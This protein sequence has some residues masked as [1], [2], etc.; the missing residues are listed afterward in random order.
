MVVSVALLVEK[1]VMQSKQGK[2]L[3]MQSTLETV[4]G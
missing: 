2:V 4:V 1:L 3:E